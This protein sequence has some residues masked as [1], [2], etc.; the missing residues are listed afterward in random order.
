M[1]LHEFQLT[2]SGDAL[3]TIYSPVMVN[4]PGTPPGTLTPLLDSIVQ[5]VD[6]RTGLVVWE[7]HSYGHIPLE[8][9]MAT[10]SNSAT[11]DA[12]HINSVQ[13]LRSG[14]LISA[15]DTSAVYKVDPASGRV[16]W[17]LGGNASNFQMG[18]G[19]QFFFQHDAHMDRAGRITMFDDEAGP[20]QKAPYSR[21]I[22]LAF[23]P[24]SHT[25]TLA[26]EYARSADTSA[27]SEGSVQTLP[28]KN[29]FVGFGSTQFF[30]EF[31][32]GGQLLFDGSLPQNDGSYRI[33]RFPWKA[34]P[35]TPPAVVVHRTDPSNVSLYV[36]WN[37]ATQVA[38]WQI[39]AG[40]SAGSLA[41]VKK[42]P[43]TGFETQVD[44]P[45]SATMFGVRALSSS[46][47]VLGRSPAVPAS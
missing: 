19:A 39:L 38:R 3:F 41:P 27:Q 30:S 6:I 43:K 26:G 13:P 47:R 37:G 11:Y 44:L 20:P 31:S 36:S 5:E 10:P 24:K 32:P 40:Q 25:A 23:D 9:S 1:D 16:L 34:T 35:K 17:T 22:A 7:W 8:Q 42:V 45:S 18:P 21:G 28:D 46:G 14:V 2:G 33:Y 12:F 15:R 4:L 29:V